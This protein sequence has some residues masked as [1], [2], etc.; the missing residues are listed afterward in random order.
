LPAV[1]PIDIV[2]QHFPRDAEK[3]NTG[4][5]ILLPRQPGGRRH[6]R[7]KRSAR[8]AVGQSNS[9]EGAYK[10][11]LMIASCQRWRNEQPDKKI[12]YLQEIWSSTVPTPV[13]AVVILN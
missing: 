4:D 6:P 7:Y 9:A 8:R 5:N 1:I 2:V 12:A 3:A 10:T 11:R 13:L